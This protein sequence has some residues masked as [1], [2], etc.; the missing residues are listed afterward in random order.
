MDEDWSAC[1]QGAVGFLGAQC[2]EARGWGAQNPGG[3]W[4]PLAAVEMQ[5]LV[6]PKPPVA[7][8]TLVVR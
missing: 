3:A 5:P 4:L 6:L 1:S 2:E 8:A 7:D